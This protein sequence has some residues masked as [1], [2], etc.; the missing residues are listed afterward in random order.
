MSAARIF[1][2][3]RK[4]RHWQVPHSDRSTS[5]SG[6]STDWKDRSQSFEDEN[7]FPQCKELSFPSFPLFALFIFYD[8]LSNFPFRI[9]F[10]PSTG[11]HPQKYHIHPSSDWIFEWLFWSLALPP[12]SLISKDQQTGSYNLQS[13]LNHNSEL[14]KCFEVKK[15]SAYF[16]HSYTSLLPPPG[17]IW[18]AKRCWVTCC[19]RSLDTLLKAPLAYKAS[20]FL[21]SYFYTKLPIVSDCRWEL[22][23]PFSIPFRQ[24]CNNVQFF[25]CLEP[26]RGGSWKRTF[27]Y[28]VHHIFTERPP[29]NKSNPYAF[30]MCFL[31][32][33]SH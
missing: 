33:S 3:S 29:I 22:F 12:S 28:A 5:N 6:E 10:L 27:R 31:S 24:L 2:T 32:L 14:R 15:K 16:S 18:N 9:I 30:Y 21:S 4:H 1:V 20:D 17:I 11:C 7:I 13:D 26:C 8:I 19:L 25:L 23:F